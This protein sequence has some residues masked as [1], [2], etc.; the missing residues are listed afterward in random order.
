MC[1]CVCARAR[2][3]A[4]VEHWSGGGG[5]ERLRSTMTL[6]RCTPGRTGEAAV[7]GGGQDHGKVECTP[8][9]S[10]PARELARSL[11]LER[12]PAL[13][14]NAIK[15]KH[16]SPQNC[17]C[18]RPRWRTN[19]TIQLRRR[20]AKG[21]GRQSSRGH[22]SPIPAQCPCPPADSSRPRDTCKGAPS[23][24]QSFLP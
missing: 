24:S 5:G 7:D 18:G 20:I 13:V 14:A 19:T 23:Q 1:V 16:A 22:P 3:C 11:R 21:T 2:A 15:T 6:P 10:A 8:S 9:N 17:A 4:C 12:N